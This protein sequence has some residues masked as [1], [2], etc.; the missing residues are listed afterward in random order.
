[1][2]NFENRQAERHFKANK[3]K[4]RS[5]LNNAKIDRIGALTIVSAAIDDEEQKPGPGEPGYHSE[6]PNQVDM[7]GGVGGE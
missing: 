5:F 3:K 7:F 1:M 6:D 4:D 2:S